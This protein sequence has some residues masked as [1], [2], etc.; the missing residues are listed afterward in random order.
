MDVVDA[1]QLFGRNDFLDRHLLGLGSLFECRCHCGLVIVEFVVTLRPVL[2][3]TIFILQL[4]LRFHYHSAAGEHPI[5][6]QQTLAKIWTHSRICDLSTKPRLDGAQT[7]TPHR[8]APQRRRDFGAIPT[9]AGGTC[10]YH[11]E[12][13]KGSGRSHYLTSLI[14][15]SRLA[16]Y[17]SAATLLLNSILTISVHG[18][19]RQCQY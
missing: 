14:I 13:W 8:C 4:G 19:F 12:Y 2:D 10:Q 16:L 9:A 5:D 3:W 1:P 18:L 11:K 7:S 17:N 15:E 6:E